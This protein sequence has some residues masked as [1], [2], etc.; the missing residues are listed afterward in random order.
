MSN[1]FIHVVFS[2][3]VELKIDR[4]DGHTVTSTVIVII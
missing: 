2:V 3:S 4:T 1:N